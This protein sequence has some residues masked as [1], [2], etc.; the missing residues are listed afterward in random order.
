[1]INLFI[2]EPTRNNDANAE[3]DSTKLRIHLLK[4]LETVLWSTIISL[5]RAEARM[6]LRKTIAGFNCVKP[7]DQREIF[8][9][10]MRIPK[11][12]HDL[13]SQFLNL[14]FDNSPQK[15]GSVLAR[16]TRVL[17]NFFTGEYFYFLILFVVLV[18]VCFCCGKN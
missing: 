11:K 17:E 10:F 9:N 13:A 14:M 2:S 15:L 4:E 5:G 16:K 1:M 6:W 8:I 7:R 3:E 18:Y 12:K